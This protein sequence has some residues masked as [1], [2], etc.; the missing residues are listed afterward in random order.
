MKRFWE[1]DFSRGIAIILMII[2]NWSFTLSYFNIF[3]VKGGF[4]YWFLFPRFIASMFIFIVGI[5]LVL[6]YNTIKKKDK[7]FIYLK[8]LK[9]GI[10]IFSLGLL[11][12]LATFLLFPNEFI[13]FGILHLIGI[14]TILAIP[15]L[16]FKKLN[17][18]LGSIVVV[19]GFFLQ[20]FR[21]NFSWLFWII[22]ESF[23]TF[24]YFPLF[25]WFGIVLLGLFFGNLLYKNG[26]RKY[27]VKNLSNIFIVKI[28]A[29]L[30]RNSLIIYLTHQPLLIL[31][32][33]ILGFKI[34]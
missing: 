28:L 17:L 12:T 23:I 15:F 31:V 5:S 14:S 6:S 34:F 30:G 18:I 22:P 26:K 19:F 32:L 10:K 4:L 20:N 11:I 16:K 8:Y 9:R 25:P 13:I 21:F 29:F 2:F 33:L 7:K 27:E 3:T 24:D 1:V